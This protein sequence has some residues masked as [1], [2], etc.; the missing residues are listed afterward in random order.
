MSGRRLAFA[1][2]LLSIACPQR[3]DE[4]TPT[5]AEPSTSPTIAS[6]IASKPSAVPSSINVLPAGVVAATYA[7]MGTRI[8]MRVWTDREVAAK[9]AMDDA[10]T[11]IKRI[12]D[13][14]TTWKDTSEVS[15]INAAAGGAPTPISPELVEV[16]QGARS[17]H[18]ASSGVF[19][20][21]FYAMH[22]L[23]KFDQDLV[24]NVPTDAQI[25]ERLPFVNGSLV[26]VDAEKRTARLGKKGMMINLGGIAKGYAVDK[27]T[28][29]LAKHGF[30]S[31][32]VQAGGDLLVKGRKGSEPW[33]VGIR[34]PRG[35]DGDYFALAPI[36]D[37]AFSTAGD[38]ERSFIKDGV[39]YHHIIDPRTGKP[40]TACRSVTIFAPDALTAD[41]LDDAVF[42]LGPE[43]GLPLVE[44]RE[45]VGAVIVDKDNK[46]HVS[47]RLA[48]IVQ[49]VHPP[50]DGI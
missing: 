29:V 22:G 11:E 32:M 16:L 48:G 18:D 39:R 5:R 2:S 19:D 6:A 47:K 35:P 15:K 27:A 40:A 28:A 34:D 46:V 30:T 8:E 36:T 24:A 4:P 38:Y 42:I 23:W 44:T 14:M 7:A 31:V 10:F 43:K 12:E 13:M 25:A 26:E 21:T 45:G 3:R 33:R 37:A 50:T 20:I 9:A 17:I 41:E 49:F 1:L